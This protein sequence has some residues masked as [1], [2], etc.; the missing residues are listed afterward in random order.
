M[1]LRAM[2]EA[3]LPAIHALQCAAYPP[4]YHEPEAA[5]AS[6]LAA[7]PETCFVAEREN[8][9]LAYVFA[10]PWQGEPPRLHEALPERRQADHL[11]VH[12]LAVSPTA[13][14]HGTAALLVQAVQQAA[15]TQRLEEIRLVALAQ[16]RPFWH[17]HGFEALPA[18]LPACYGEA[19]LMSD[20]RAPEIQLQRKL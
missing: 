2:R 7:G 11:F 10:H 8:R 15:S 16:A 17:R 18:A 12:D 20:L 9:L 19:C 1:K 13:R 3:D 6:H 4:D 5:L 14:G